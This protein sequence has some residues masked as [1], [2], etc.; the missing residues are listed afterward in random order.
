MTSCHVCYLFKYLFWIYRTCRVVRVDDNDSLCLVCY[1][2]FHVL[3]VRI[4]FGA[5][6][7]NIVNGS[8]ACKSNGSCPQRIVRGR[9]KNLVAV[10]EKTLH[11]HCDKLG[12]TVSGVDVV[13]T[14][15]RYALKVC[16]II[17]SL[18]CFCYAL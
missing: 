6:I 15:N 8:T 16:I 4:P 9:N 2:L 14:F 13:K 17:N 10:V 12:N 7:T 3:K 5:F 1:L 11:Y 18:S